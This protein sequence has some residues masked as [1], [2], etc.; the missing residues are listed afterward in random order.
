MFKF[1]KNEMSSAVLT[2][3]GQAT[4]IRYKVLVHDVNSDTL[5]EETPWFKCT[6]Y[7]NDVVFRQ[8]GKVFTVYGL[9]NEK[10]V[11]PGDMFVIIKDWGAKF[12]KNM[13]YVNAWLVQR[14]HPAITF[15][16]VEGVPSGNMVLRVPKWYVGNTIYMSTLWMVVRRAAYPEILT[17]DNFYENDKL[18]KFDVEARKFREEFGAT[19]QYTVANKK[20]A[21]VQKAIFEKVFNPKFKKFL[22]NMV[23]YNNSKTFAELNTGSYAEEQTQYHNAGILA[24]LGCVGLLKE[25]A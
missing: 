14:G 16:T 9:N 23:A 24:G 11:V 8:H 6:D 2:E 7:F 18:M 12:I 15:E 13:E 19:H 17:D 5:R 21:I 4:A 25:E 3:S 1:V 10:L 20:V 22:D